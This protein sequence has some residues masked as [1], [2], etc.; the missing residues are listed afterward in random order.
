MTDEQANDSLYQALDQAGYLHPKTPPSDLVTRT[1][2]HLPQ[3]A[4]ATAQRTSK[5]RHTWRVVTTGAAIAVVLFVVFA[6]MW[7]TFGVHSPVVFTFGEGDSGIS[8]LLLTLHLMSKP[9]V[10]SLGSLA[11]S[12]LFIG[13]FIAIGS[14]W[15]W[16]FLIQRTPVYAI[17]EIRK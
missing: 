1:L 10:R 4:P 16:W 3:V 2:R 12:L 8:R 13:T 9:L 14:A 5:R 17:A 6:G 7:N 15:L 11:P